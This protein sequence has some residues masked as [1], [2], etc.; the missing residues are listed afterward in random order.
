MRFQVGTGG[1][2]LQPNIGWKQGDACHCNPSG[3]P[4]TE[5][6]EFCDNIDKSACD[7]GCCGTNGC[8]HLFQTMEGGTGYWNNQLPT[9][10]VKWRINAVTGCYKTE[11][12]SPLWS[13]YGN[14][15]ACGNTGVVALSNR[16]LIAPDGIAFQNEGMLGQA[17]IDTPVGKKSPDEDGGARRS[18]T[19]VLDTDNFKG[20]VASAEINTTIPLICICSDNVLEDTDGVV[21]DVPHLRGRSW[22]R[23]ASLSVA[24]TF[25]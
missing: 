23:S 15:L 19:L 20:P 2:W 18:W 3:W 13:F 4:A 1:T 6:G 17:W 22:Q 8:E 5:T 12:A 10:A 16:F 24:L 9:T 14:E 7:N 11:T 25:C 21:V